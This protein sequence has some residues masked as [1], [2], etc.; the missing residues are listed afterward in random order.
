[1]GAGHPACPPAGHP[2]RRFQEAAGSS[3]SLGGKKWLLV[4]LLLP[5]T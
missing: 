2:A 1:M 4:K 3:R 5:V